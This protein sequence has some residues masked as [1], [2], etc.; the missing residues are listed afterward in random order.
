MAQDPSCRAPHAWEMACPVP[1]P[2]KETFKTD[3]RIATAKW[4]WKFQSDS[5]QVYFPLSQLIPSPST[6]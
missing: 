6:S 4:Q 1:P 5:L 3:P 2:K